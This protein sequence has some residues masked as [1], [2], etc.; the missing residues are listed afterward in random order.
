LPAVIHGSSAIQAQSIRVIKQP[1]QPV[2]LSIPSNQVTSAV[3]TTIYI[4]TLT[5]KMLVSQNTLNQSR[6]VTKPPL[7]AS[8][9]VKPGQVAATNSIFPVHNIKKE[10]IPAKAVYPPPEKPPTTDDFSWPRAVTGAKIIYPAH[11]TPST[12]STTTAPPSPLPSPSP[13]PSIV[14]PIKKEQEVS[15]GVTGAVR[16]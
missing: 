12:P 10:L 16:I 6:P 3:S 7:T 5:K 14:S 1:G 15:H 13:S 4:V 9:A 2:P 11:L 8:A